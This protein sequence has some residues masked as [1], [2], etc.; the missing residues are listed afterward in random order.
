MSRPTTVRQAATALDGRPGTPDGGPAPYL[1]LD[2]GRGLDPHQARCRR[3]RWRSGWRSTAA[4]VQAEYGRHQLAAHA[5]GRRRA[6]RDLR[7]RLGR[8]VR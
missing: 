8:W 6:R 2:L 7:G 1:V 4:Q 3:C 5:P